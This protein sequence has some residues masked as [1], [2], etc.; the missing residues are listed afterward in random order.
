LAAGDVLLVELL[1]LAAKLG[2]FLLAEVPPRGR[3]LGLLRWL[4]ARCDGFH[5][6]IALLALCISLRRVCGGRTREDD[7][8]DEAQLH[9][10]RLNARIAA[11]I[12]L[13]Q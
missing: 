5:V 1:Q 2:A 11:H 10:C 13:I 9:D 3:L 4:G 8:K 6:R 7:A 12:T